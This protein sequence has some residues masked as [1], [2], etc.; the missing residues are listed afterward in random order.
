VLKYD[1]LGQAVGQAFRVTFACR[2]WYGWRTGV[3]L[4]VEVRPSL[5][6]I[7]IGHSER[8]C[9]PI[10]QAD[11]TDAKEFLNFARVRVVMLEQ[12]NRS[13]VPERVKVCK[14]ALL[15]PVPEEVRVGATLHLLCRRSFSDPRCPCGIKIGLQHL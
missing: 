12:C 14:P 8:S 10:N 13:G 2:R 9:V 11:T 6:D 7:T 3:G 15:I 5:D 1:L 4:V